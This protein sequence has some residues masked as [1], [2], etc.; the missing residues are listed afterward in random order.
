MQFLNFHHHN[1]GFSE[2]GIYNLNLEESIPHIPLS[3]AIHPYNITNDWEKDFEKV[4]EVSVLPNCFAIGECGLDARIDVP[5]DIQE[6]VFKKHIEWANEINK[7][8]IIHCVRRFQEVIHLCKK[9]DSSKAIHGFNKHHQLANS[10]I[11]N[12]FYLSFGKALIQ[13]VSLQNIVKE[14]PLEKIFLETDDKD[15]SILELYQK[16]AQLKDITVEYLC[17]Q[18][19]DNFKIFF[20]R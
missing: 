18:I 17:H 12:G 2:E 3:I 1:I 14:I 20:S 13:N 9:A 19:M 6:L 7:P 15:F 8:I 16:V 4:K 10:L 11:S 5:I